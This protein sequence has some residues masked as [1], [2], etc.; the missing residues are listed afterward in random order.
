M[1][2]RYGL[3]G[4][5]LPSTTQTSGMWLLTETEYAPALSARR[6]VLEL[7]QSHYSVP[8]WDDPL[9][10]ITLGMKI[11]VKGT[12]ADNLR[13]QWNVLTGLLGM[14]SNQ[15]VKLTRYRD[16]TTETADGQLVSS[17]TPAYEHVRNVLDVQIVMNIPGGSWRSVSTSDQSFAAG[18]GQ[19][20]TVANLSTRPITDAL[21]RI[22]GPVGTVTITDN[23]SQTG[24]SWT[25]ASLSVPTGSYLLIDPSIMVAKIVSTDTW[26]IT[27]GTPASA[28]LVYTGYGPLTLTSRRT[29][30]SATAT[31]SLTVQLSGGSGPVVI[32]AKTAVV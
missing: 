31:S 26:D 13:T 29:G 8:M 24:I 2:V 30:V 27:I 7:P 12:S 6:A 32:R 28:R 14:G 11:R 18:A 21:I 23:T 4:Y 20:V 16:A 10:E 19:S 25:N 5:I 1:S 3:N 22:P 9:S 15:P 17:T